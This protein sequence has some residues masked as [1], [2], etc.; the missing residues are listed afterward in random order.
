M[1]ISQQINT[2]DY[3][4]TMSNDGRIFERGSRMRDAITE[5]LGKMPP[6]EIDE[7]S[8]K[9]T[10]PMDLVNK[11][12][13]SFFEV[14]P[15]ETPSYRSR[16]FRIAWYFYRKGLFLSFSGALRAAWCCFK[17][18][19]ALRGGEVKMCYRKSNGTIREARGTLRRDILAF[20][21]TDSRKRNPDVVAYWDLEKLAWRAFR[22][23]RLISF[24]SH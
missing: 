6:S 16:I 24:T 13:K 15:K 18:V 23:E 22:I 14:N 21:P 1:E 2:F 3:Y 7:L 9:I 11:Y 5:A 4:Y 20:Y 12:W 17:A 8:S 10:V 19:L